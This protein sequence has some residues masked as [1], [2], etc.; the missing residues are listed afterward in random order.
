MTR[1]RNPPSATA[2][3]PAARQALRRARGA[4][5]VRLAAVALSPLDCVAVRAGDGTRV[6]C[7]TRLV[8]EETVRQRGT[9]LGEP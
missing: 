7:L 2:A 5:T 6:A 1:T 3:T 9:V 4:Q 8:H